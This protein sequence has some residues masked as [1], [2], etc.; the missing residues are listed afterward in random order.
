[1]NAHFL[2]DSF[3]HVPPNVP[4]GFVRCPRLCST[5]SQPG[6]R[7]SARGQTE[8]YRRAGPTLG[9]AQT[10]APPQGLTPR[11]LRN[12]T[13]RPCGPN[14]SP[15]LCPRR[16]RGHSSQGSGVH[17][18]RREVEPARARGWAGPDHG[19]R[20]TRTSRRTSRR[21]DRHEAPRSPPSSGQ[22][23]HR[24]Q[25]ACETQCGTAELRKAQVSCGFAAG[26]HCG[27]KC[28]MCGTTVRNRPALAL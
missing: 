1:M 22:A 28:G 11:M 10:V 17:T 24:L 16:T 5:E 12:Q 4:P 6:Q 20:V 19:A 3:F 2:D 14:D 15:C 13:A 9:G 25:P 21:R 18:L 26:R 7:P 23:T 8:A 27:T